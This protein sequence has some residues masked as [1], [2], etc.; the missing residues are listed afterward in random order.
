MPERK[1]HKQLS[2]PFAKDLPVTPRWKSLSRRLVRLLYEHER[3]YPCTKPPTF[4]VTARRLRVADACC[5][6]AIKFAE[7]EGW[8]TL[9]GNKP[10]VLPRGVEVC[11]D[12]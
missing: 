6:A 5:R 11:I 8:I 4:K 12:R 3:D 9:K 10:Y 7:S 2:F 1:K